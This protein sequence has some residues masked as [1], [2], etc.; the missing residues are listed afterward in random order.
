MKLFHL[1]LVSLK[2]SLFI[3]SGI[4]LFLVRSEKD[5]DNEDIE[6]SPEFTHQIFGEK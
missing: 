1:N 4:S 2:I 6:F 3:F 5:L